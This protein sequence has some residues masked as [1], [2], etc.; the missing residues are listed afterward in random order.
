MK[1][2]LKQAKPSFCSKLSARLFT[3]LYST[4]LYTLAMVPSCLLSQL[5]SSTKD[6]FPEQ[7][8]AL[9]VLSSHL[10]QWENHFVD[11]YT[12][13]Q[14]TRQD[15]RFFTSQSLQTANLPRGDNWQ[16][17]QS[18]SKTTFSLGDE[19]RV[20]FC[21]LNTRKAK[22]VVTRS[23]PFKV[24]IFHLDFLREDLTLHFAWCEK[25]D[26]APADISTSMS[27]KPVKQA[28]F[29]HRVPVYS[30]NSLSTPVVE[31]PTTC[32]DQI[33]VEELYFLRDFIDVELG[34]EFGWW[35]DSSSSSSPSCSP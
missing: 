23:P 14:L 26:R 10:L 27:V 3:I 15:N 7:R 29:H 9:D 32:I 19:L 4:R 18:R 25:G 34:Q 11:D 1:R 24:W 8:R 22:D 6:M 33:S 16:W 30:E 28:G 35:S 20:S 17:N 12:L 21:K 5:Q 13:P 2:H 31:L